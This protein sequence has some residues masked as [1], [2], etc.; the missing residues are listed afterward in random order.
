MLFGFLLLARKGMPIIVHRAALASPSA[1]PPMAI[2][3]RRRPAKQASM[4][5]ATQA[6]PRSAAHPFYTRLNQ[7]S[8][9]DQVETRQA[10][11]RSRE[12]RTGPL[13]QDVDSRWEVAGHKDAVPS[14]AALDTAMPSPGAI[15]A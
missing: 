8:D 7:I 14:R 2:G 1:L 13:P 9:E 3:K 5:V 11:P 10:S 6:L 12:D 4:W 15:H